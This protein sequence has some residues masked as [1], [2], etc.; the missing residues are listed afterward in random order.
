[1]GRARDEIL[2][3]QVPAMPAGR[4]ARDS[5]DERRRR[6]P[7]RAEERREPKRDSGIELH[8]V[9]ARPPAEELEVRVR[10]IVGNDAAARIE[11]NDTERM[12]ELDGKDPHFQRVAGFGALDE[13]WPAQWMRAGAALGDAELDGL[14]RLRN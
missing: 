13:D 8:T 6:H 10:K 4:A 5:S 14:Q 2:V 7:D 11:G 12:Q 3:V 9:R 1:Q